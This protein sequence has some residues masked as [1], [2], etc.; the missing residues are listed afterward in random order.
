LAAALLTKGSAYVVVIVAVV[1]V[2]FRWRRE[3]R[4]VRWAVG[5]LA[6]MLVPALLLSAP[7]FIRNGLTYGWHDPSG[8]VRHGEVVA[9]QMRTSEYLALNGWAAYW[10]R[11]VSFTFQSFWG[12]FG[13]M[14][15]VLPARI[16][17]ALAL[18]SGLLCVGF[19][20]WLVRQRRAR[21]P[22]NLPI[23]QLLLLPL[24][25]SLTFAVFVSYNL[26]FLQHQGRYLFPAL[27][28]IGAAAA[29]GMSTLAKV[30]PQRTRPWAIA[31]FFAGLAAFDVYCLYRFI[32]PTL[33]R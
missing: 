6:W 20:V 4:T 16:Y 30:L 1:A 21:Q 9:E 24:S 15:V 33:T 14:G 5:Q 32:I 10:K 28:P 2:P 27:I 13:W 23:Y 17:Q 22:T 8:Q 26:T 3:R 29:L 7:W 11:A 31:A 18:L 19:V 12:Q 25:A